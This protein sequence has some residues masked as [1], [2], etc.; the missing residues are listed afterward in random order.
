[1][2]LFNVTDTFFMHNFRVNNLDFKK[3][4]VLEKKK[5]ENGII[6]GLKMILKIK[7]ITIGL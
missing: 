4:F 6:Y 5:E 2:L 1:M 3:F 7:I